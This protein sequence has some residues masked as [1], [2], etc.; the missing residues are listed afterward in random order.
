MSAS[1]DRPG[2]SPL[3][4]PGDRAG[5]GQPPYGQ[6]REHA[7]G[8]VGALVCGIL[9]LVTVPVILSVVAV[10]LGTKSK[11]AAEAE[12]QRYNDD[13]GQVGR[14]LGWIGIVLGGLV[15]LVVVAMI[16]FFVT[17]G[18][19]PPVDMPPEMPGF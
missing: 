15:V 1:P 17:W 7:P 11:R 14:I 9:G 12:P 13:L 3:P 5:H 19:P 8:A 10:V 4:P 6:P 18:M 16:A 2:R